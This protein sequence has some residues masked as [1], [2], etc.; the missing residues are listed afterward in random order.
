MLSLDRSFALAAALAVLPAAAL[1]DEPKPTS[2][3]DVSQINGQLVPVGEHNEYLYNFKRWNVSTNPLGWVLGS[4]G[5][6]VSY[7][8]HENFA[9]RGD[10]NYFSPVG[11]DVKGFELGAGVPIYFRR[12]YQ[13]AFLEPGIIVRQFSESG[14]YSST[15][16]GPQVL[17]GW[18]WTWDSGLNIAAAVGVGR[19]WS[20]RSDGDSYYDKEQIFANGYLRFGYNF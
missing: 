5:V 14:G 6:S 1:A 13:G 8:V 2:P 18:H 11:T 7:G 12:T 9:L 15:T 20:S 16:F 10:V 17:V 19:D 3:A 4:Y